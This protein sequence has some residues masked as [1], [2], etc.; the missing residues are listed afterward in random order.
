MKAATKISVAAGTSTEKKQYDNSGILFRN[1]DKTKDTDRDYSG[2][3]TVAGVEYWLSAWVK[4]G[5]KGKFLSLSLKPKN[6]AP[7]PAT[8]SQAPGRSGD[9]NDFIPF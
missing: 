4:E 1:D 5:R 7:A 8:K 2:S 6:P 9:L 3:I